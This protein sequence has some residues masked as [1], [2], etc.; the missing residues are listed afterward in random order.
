M[1]KLVLSKRSKYDY[2]VAANCKKH[3]EPLNATDHKGELYCRACYG[4]KFG[5]KGY[6]YAGGAGTGLSTDTEER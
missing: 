3:L 2:V 1:P 4:R 6:G 5:P